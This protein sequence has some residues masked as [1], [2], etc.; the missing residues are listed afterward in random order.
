MNLGYSKL[1][2]SILGSRTSE[3]TPT[4]NGWSVDQTTGRIKTSYTLDMDSKDIINIRSLLSSSGKWSLDVDGKLVVEE[5]ETKKLKVTS[6][7]GFTIYDED[8]LQPVCVKS[9]S[10]VLA[11]VP[12]ECG[13]A[14]STSTTATST[15]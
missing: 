15:P 2:D 6:P 3:G 9:K 8:T 1:D 14:V 4:S 7:N 11:V 13:V 10:G 5:I 12:G